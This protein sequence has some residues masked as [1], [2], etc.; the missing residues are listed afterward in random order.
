MGGLLLFN[1]INWKDGAHLRTGPTSPTY[2][3]RFDTQSGMPFE[4]LKLREQGT[5][6][7]GTGDWGARGMGTTTSTQITWLT[8]L[9]RPNTA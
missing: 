7:L 9:D 8:R 2:A 5:R 6:D 3:N 1:R 4:A